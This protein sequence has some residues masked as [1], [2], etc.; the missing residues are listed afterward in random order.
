MVKQARECAE[1]E[2]RS[3][4]PQCRAKW[5]AYH[6]QTP[7]KV[8]LH[9]EKIGVESH[10]SIIPGP[11]LRP[12]GAVTAKQRLAQSLVAIAILAPRGPAIG[13]EAGQEQCEA[14]GGG[15]FESAL[16]HTVGAR[17]LSGGAPVPAARCQ[18]ARRVARVDV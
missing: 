9:L 8:E 1:D 11:S 3:Y 15:P 13:D 18:A 17:H 16:L 10:R 2:D 7:R 12:Y 6:L 14:R 5:R 4:P